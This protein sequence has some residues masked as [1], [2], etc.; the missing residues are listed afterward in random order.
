VALKRQL[1]NEFSLEFQFES[2]GVIV[3]FDWPSP[4]PFPRECEQGE[5]VQ[6][7]RCGHGYVIVLSISQ[8][9][10]TSTL[11]VSHPCASEWVRC[12]VMVIVLFVKVPALIVSKLGLYVLPHSKTKK[13]VLKNKHG[14]EKSKYTISYLLLFKGCGFIYVQDV[15][16]G[17]HH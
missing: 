14:N 6:V 7:V 11:W 3:K 13:F 12:I 5:P 1:I 10:L 17:E 16:I 8:L 9:T 4:V 15:S 2:E